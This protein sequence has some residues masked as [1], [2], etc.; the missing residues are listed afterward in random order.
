MDAMMNLVNGIGMNAAEVTRTLSEIGGGNMLDGISNIYN[1]ALE[2]GQEI[3]YRTRLFEEALEA[4]ENNTCK[5]VVIGGACFLI[6]AGITAGGVWLAK[7]VQAKKK[8]SNKQS[9]EFIDDD[10]SSN[11]LESVV[12]QNL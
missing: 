7:R 1:N 10:T 3:G 2:Y 4:P 5:K 11:K 8:E 12:E 9:K 6:G